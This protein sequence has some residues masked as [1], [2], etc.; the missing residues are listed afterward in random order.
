MGAVHSKNLSYSY[1][2]ESRGQVSGIPTDH[3]GLYLYRSKICVKFAIQMI[4]FRII[5][6]RIAFAMCASPSFAGAALFRNAG[7]QSTLGQLNLPCS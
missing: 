1:V 5:L 4:V 2:N 3:H 7:V 6:V